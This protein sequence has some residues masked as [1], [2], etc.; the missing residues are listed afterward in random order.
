MK[1]QWAKN[2]NNG[3]NFNNDSDNKCTFFSANFSDI[4]FYASAINS[5]CGSIMISGG[6][7]TGQSVVH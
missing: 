6:P 1:Y 5:K 2:N 4:S 7:C 3:H